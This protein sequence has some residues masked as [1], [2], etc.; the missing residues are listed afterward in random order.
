[1]PKNADNKYGKKWDKKLPQA[2]PCIKCG[3]KDITFGDCGYSSFNPGWVHCQG[4]GHSVELNECEWGDRVEKT[5]RR[6]WNGERKRM[7][8]RVKRLEKEL[9][10]LKKWLKGDR[11]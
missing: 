11:S 3:S 1:M 8:N 10:Q 6:V 5:L 4:C 7:E 2:K 9:K